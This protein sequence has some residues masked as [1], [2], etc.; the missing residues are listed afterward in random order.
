MFCGVPLF[1]LCNRYFEYAAGIN[2]LDLAKL[3]ASYIGKD[4]PLIRRLEAETDRRESEQGVETVK[5]CGHLVDNINKVP[6]AVGTSAKY[7]RRRM[8]KDAPQYLE[9]WERGE[10]RSVR[11]AAKAAAIEAVH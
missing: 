9:A 6:R 2:C 4:H 8:A 11:A 10:Y 3:L 1:R 7:L 5:A